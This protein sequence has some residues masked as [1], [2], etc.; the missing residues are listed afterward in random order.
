ASVTAR[1]W[2]FSGDTNY[3][4]VGLAGMAC[5]GAGLSMTT[6]M[7]RPE[8]GAPP[9]TDDGQPATLRE[10]RGPVG[11]AVGLAE[12]AARFVVHY[13][14]YILLVRLARPGR[15][16]FY[17]WACAAV[18]A[19]YAA[20]CFAAIGWNLG[21]TCP[22]A[23]PSSSPQAWAAASCPTRTRCPSAWCPSSAAPCSRGRATCSAPTAP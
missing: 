1:L 5:L 11:I 20:R 19:L 21:R 8:Y 2:R 12:R 6:F 16:A 9:P 7:R 13:P 3:L 10:L 14:S 15:F 4:L 18:N 17:S 22:P 23:A